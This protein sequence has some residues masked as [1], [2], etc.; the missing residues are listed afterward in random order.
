ML[1]AGDLFDVASPPPEAER[2]VY[3]ALLDLAAGGRQVVVV[4]GNHDGPAPAGRGG[5][6]GGPGGRDRRGWRAAP[7]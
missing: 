4:A 5:A 1:V 7:R 2:L 3:R 6:A